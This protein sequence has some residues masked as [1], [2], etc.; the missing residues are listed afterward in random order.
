M[1]IRH[2]QLR[3][4]AI[5]SLADRAA[6][7]TATFVPLALSSETPVRRDYGDEILL[8][9]IEN[10]DMSRA[11]PNGLPLLVS[12]DDHQLPIG[13]LKNLRIEDTRLRGDAYFSGRP[14]AQAIRQDV[15]DGIVTD[16]SVGYRIIDYKV[17][18]ATSASEVNRVLI[19]RW[20]PREGSM[21]ASGADNTVGIGRAEDQALEFD[22]D[23]DRAADP[24]QAEETPKEDKEEGGEETESEVAPVND[25][26]EEQNH[27]IVAPVLDA[28]SQTA[29]GDPQTIVTPPAEVAAEKAQEEAQPIGVL[30]AAAEEEEKLAE[31]EKRSNPEL[32][33]EELSALRSVAL[34]LHFRSES[35]VDAILANTQDLEAARALL[36]K[37]QTVT[38]AK[39][40]PPMSFNNALMKGLHQAAR[41]E[42]ASLNQ[43][44]LQGA[45]VQTGA[46]SFS[47]DIFGTRANEMTTTVGGASTIYEQNIG[48]LDL[49]RAR[50][51]V[52]SAGGR[53]RQGIGQLS[54]MRQKAASTA[55]LRAELGSVSNTYPDFEK[56]SYT[57][58]ALTARVILTDELQKESIL[59]LQS[60]LRNDIV[61]QFAIAL[62]A[63][64]LNGAT[65][66]VTIG[67][68][69]SSGSGIYSGNLATAAL[70]TFA[71]VNNL[72]AKVDQTAV[73][74]AA[75]AFITTPSL[76]A[77]LETTSKFSGNMGFP[78]ADAN[79]IN[80]YSAYTSTNCPITNVG[81]TPV[82]PQ[83]TLIFGDFSQL[84]LCLQGA[85]EF[86]VNT[87]SYFAEGLT[88]LS[89][90][91][92]FDVGILHPKA[93][94]SCGNFLVA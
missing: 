10:I 64:S 7:D 14:D 43:E 33:I 73:D 34:S 35:E 92:Y 40:T 70:P 55:A 61:K 38:H 81:T 4:F 19:T 78:I 28:E 93:F 68:L 80:G 69:L 57:P 50:T 56:V 16:V 29:E 17:E 62:D 26:E 3:Q 76:M 74:L 48:F 45:I 52:L 67:G 77:V 37:P 86:D 71:A 60:A 8:H 22:L 15:I 82:V 83:H 58:K 12:Q 91:V 63:Y 39:E 88:I 72:K 66:S 6:A 90:R 54:Y 31:G 2:N 24:D 65:G 20:M 18:K 36:L 13:R 32:Y 42:F 49:L 59:D 51:A 75:C 89:A 1:K 44:D 9:G 53:T 84:E 41:G 85:V 27:G 21:V 5:E 94:A 23:L 46:R 87:T 47:A 25:T 11:T 79:K 30:E